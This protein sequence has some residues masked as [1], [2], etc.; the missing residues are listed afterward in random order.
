MLEDG[1]SLQSP[2]RLSEAFEERSGPTR[3][4]YGVLRVRG[5]QF[6]V[7]GKRYP[8]FRNLE[9]IKLYPMQTERRTMDCNI[10]Y[11]GIVAE[12]HWSGEDFERMSF[13]IVEGFVTCNSDYVS[14][15]PVSLK[16][17]SDN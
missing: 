13:K 4:A 6:R 14:Y 1:N 11:A 10:V 5:P 3:F 12:G 17:P 8:A 15:N 9:A 2:N 7:S 16:R